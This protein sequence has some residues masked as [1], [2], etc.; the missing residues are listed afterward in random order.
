MIATVDIFFLRAYHYLQI[1]E[2][3]VRPALSVANTGS[4][5]D[6]VTHAVRTSLARRMKCAVLE[7]AIRRAA[8]AVT[9]VAT[10]VRGTTVERVGGR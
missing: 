1:S 6:P 10:V 7:D 8:N 3:A 5:C 4:A 9:T 2:V